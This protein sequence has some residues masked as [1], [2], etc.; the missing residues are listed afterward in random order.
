MAYYRTT[1]RKGREYMA[2]IGMT[3]Y[4]RKQSRL[5]NPWIY[6]IMIGFYGGVIW[7]VFH[8]LAYVLK[9]TSLL[10]GYL[11]DPFFRQPFLRTWW[12]N[13]TGIVF[14]VLFSVAAALLYWVLLGR[15][16][17]PW[18]GLIYGAL[19]WA[20]MFYAVGPFFDMTE[21]AAKLGLNTLL[22]EL[23]IHVLWG[24]FI[25]YSIAFEFHDEAS[26]EPL[27]AQ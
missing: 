3:A 25:G 13:L 8:W 1:E 19:W 14:F 2:M 17:G 11:A 7:S 12:G 9:F 21:P 4:R 27:S 24:L 18:P 15:F 26:R 20:V 16:R 23:S 10:P 6:S 22:T 5:T